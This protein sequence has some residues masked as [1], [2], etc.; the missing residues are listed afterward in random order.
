MGMNKG[1]RIVPGRLT[2]GGDVSNQAGPSRRVFSD[3]ILPVIVKEGTLQLINHVCG[4]QVKLII[5]CKGF[6]P[7]MAAD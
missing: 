7:V 5:L 2:G 6:M 4:L 1:C 3:S